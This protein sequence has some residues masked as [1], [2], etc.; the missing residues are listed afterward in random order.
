MVNNGQ[1]PFVTFKDPSAS[2]SLQSAIDDAYTKLN[3][4]STVTV[5]A[6]YKSTYQPMPVDAPGSVQVAMRDINN[7]LAIL[8]GAKA[9]GK[10]AAN[11][12]FN[13][14]TLQG[15]SRATVTAINDIYSKLAQA[16]K[17]L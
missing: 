3:Q 5:G 14:P 7:K 11:I 17:N 4:I 6:A 16:A 12:Q 15:A 13:V 1:Q 10:T 9:Q 2:P 8:A